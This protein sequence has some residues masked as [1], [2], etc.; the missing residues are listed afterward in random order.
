MLYTLT[1]CYVSNEAQR[2]VP[3][4]DERGNEIMLQVEA[5]S[6]TATY[7]HPDVV[8]FCASEGNDCRIKGVS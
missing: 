1:F 7:Y 3:L 6:K 4:V 2:T 8:A 5:S